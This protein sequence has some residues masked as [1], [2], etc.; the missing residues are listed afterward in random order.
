MIKVIGAKGKIIDVDDFL[1]KISIFSKKNNVIIQT[2]D[3]DLVFGKNHIFSAVDHALRAIERKTNTTNSLE[4]EILL[5]ASGERQIK[6]AIQKIGVKLK[7]EKMVFV[8]VNNK[9]KEI[10]NI[11][12]KDFLDMLCLVRNDN[13]I[14]GDEKTLIRFGIKENEIKTVMNNKY[15]DLILEKVAL[16]DIIK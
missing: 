12:L 11:I 15:A 14:E 6:L 4:K 9:K 7:N 2:F 10:S 13:V 5:Y 1:E 3:A 16:V 8:F